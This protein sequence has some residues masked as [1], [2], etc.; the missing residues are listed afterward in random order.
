LL[1]LA[2]V[3][4]SSAQKKTLNAN[5][6]VNKSTVKEI[7]SV[8]RNPSSTNF[9]VFYDNPEVNAF[10]VEIKN[11]VGQVIFHK[12]YAAPRTTIIEEIDLSEQSKGIYYIE[13]ISPD[14]LIVK[15]LTLI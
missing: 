5:T 15:K 2:S 3:Q 1:F 10:G 4:Y 8:L 14:K 9:I 13:I 11:D 12:S 6:G 7:F